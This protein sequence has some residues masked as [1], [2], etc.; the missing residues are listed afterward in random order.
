MKRSLMVTVA[1]V[2]ICATAFAQGGPRPGGQPG[3]PPISAAMTILPPPPTALD[4]LTK[5]LSL[6]DQQAAD[7]KAVLEAGDAALVP[8]MKAAS[9]AAKS[10]HDAV[11]AE[12]YDAD[13]V[14]A[15]VSASADAEAAVIASCIDTWSK[16]RGILSA[17]QF[18]R[19]AKCPGPGGTPPAGPP[20][21]GK[22]PPSSDSSSTSGLKSGPARR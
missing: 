22:I 3:A 4:A 18:A 21:G 11:F 1:F 7:L 17:D 15:A 8:L 19:I 9:D 16:I 14:A 12:T 5:L 2:V 20:P 10:V 6:T 13:A